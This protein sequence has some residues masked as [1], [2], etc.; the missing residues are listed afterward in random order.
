MR[1]V[2]TQALVVGLLA[3]SMG[4]APVGKN[5]SGSKVASRT[6]PKATKP[7][8]VGRASWYGKQFDGRSTASGETYN[9]FHLTAAHRELPLGTRIK[10]TNL[11]NGK[12]AI[13]RVNDRGPFILDRVIDLSYAA[14][15]VLQF[16]ERGLERVRID[17]VARPATDSLTASLTASLMD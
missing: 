2:L 8:Q 15:E 3:A 17:V 6:S 7:Y 12:W 16:R 13:V 1:R 14:A 9:M 5:S 4:A 11:R 10:V